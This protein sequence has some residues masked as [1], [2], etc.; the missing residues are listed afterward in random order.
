MFRSVK[1]RE[2][3]KIESFTNK[4]L[5]KLFKEVLK[6]IQDAHGFA[7]ASTWF[8]DSDGEDLSKYLISLTR[9]IGARQS[10]DINVPEVFSL[11]TT[12]SKKSLVQAEEIEFY[13]VLI[14]IQADKKAKK[15]FLQEDVAKILAELSEINSVI[16]R[17]IIGHY[18]K[19]LW[20]PY[21]YIGPAYDL[22]Y[23]L[24][25]WS[26]LV[27]QRCN[28]TEEVKRIEES[29]KNTIKLRVALIKKLKLSQKERQVFDLTAEIVWL[30][31]YRKEVSFLAYY[32]LG[33][34]MKELAKRASLS[35]NQINCVLH[36]EMQNFDKMSAEVLNERYKFS[37]MSLQNSKLV[38]MTGD[39]GRAFLKKQKFEVIKKDK[40]GVLTGTTAYAGVVSGVVKIVNHPEDMIK[41]NEGDVMVAHTTFPSLVPAMKKAA[42]IVTDDGGVTCH[43]AIVA[44]ELKKPCV[45]GTKTATKDLKDGDMIEVDANLGIIKKIK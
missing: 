30:K 37:V 8:V 2:K 11:L 23:Y 31:N 17:K 43:A 45:V 24:S 19:W 9:E 18:K 5:V 34:I 15:V 6:K 35:I 29:R 14:E 40:S 28:P 26:S 1:Q 16:T 41:M 25:L 13:G 10:G 38:V 20:M 44:R 32:F 4:E 3:L 7:V 42:A 22:E 39:K 36:T 12:P 33:K 21:G 27:R